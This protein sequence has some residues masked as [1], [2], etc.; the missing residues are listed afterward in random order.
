MDNI[1]ASQPGSQSPLQDANTDLEA[2]ADWSA[3]SKLPETD[4][5][6]A[7]ELR[8][9]S[10]PRSEKTIRPNFFFALQVS[11]SEAVMASIKSVH[12]SLLQHSAGLQAALVEPET[13]HLTIM[14]T[15]LQA[16]DDVQRAEAAMESFA[17][18]TAL[19]STL[20]QPLTLTLEGLSHFRH[21]V[22]F[23]DI[24]KDA[25]H[26]RL[27]A[28][29]QAARQHLQTA[30]VNST[31]DRDFV[32]HVTIAKMSK[33]NGRRRKQVSSPKNIAEES[34]AEHIGIQ[35]GIVIVTELQLCPMQVRQ[36]GFYYNIQ[37]SVKIC[38]AHVED[39]TCS[40]LRC[41]SISMR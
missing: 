11:R 29:V 6:S 4:C 15:A 5:K 31:D 24:K 20:A 36:A 17:A 30:G 22:L 1:A 34:Y 2:A 25:Q 3:W 37:K 32:A 41:R 40:A 28:F 38:P 8:K 21:Q 9:R 26:E 27:M 39:T 16:E 13:A 12:S 23:L 14:V 35:A 33:V 7:A 10:R 19:Y 18:D